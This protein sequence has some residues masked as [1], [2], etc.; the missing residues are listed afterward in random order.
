MNQIK[1]IFILMIVGL[2]IAWTIAAPAQAQAEALVFDVE[3]EHMDFP[4]DRI[5]GTLQGATYNSFIWLLGRMY[6]DDGGTFLVYA[7]WNYRRR[8]LVA[9]AFCADNVPCP[10]GLYRLTIIEKKLP[11]GYYR[12][13]RFVCM[14]GVPCL[15]PEGQVCFPDKFRDSVA[16]E[17]PCS[18][19]P[20]G[21]E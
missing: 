18:L 8:T 4:E 1:L 11:K 16:R 13:G 12:V 7:W 15:S 6:S 5:S 21:H 20:E 17:I 3:G 14:Q 9:E 2:C 10:Q 19:G